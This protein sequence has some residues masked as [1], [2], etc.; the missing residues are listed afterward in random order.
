M[1]TP[2]DL[3]RDPRLFTTS[4]MALLI[5]RFGVE[6]MEWDPITVGLEIESE[7]GIEPTTE[8]QDR[9]QAGCSLYTSNLFFVS[10]ETFSTICN[11]LNFGSTTSQILLPADLDDVMWGCSEA[12]LILGDIYDEKQFSHNVRLFT[13]ALL[14]EAGFVKPPSILGFAEF[15]EDMVL[16]SDEA[17]AGDEHMRLSFWADQ[18]H[19]KEMLETWNQGKIIALMQQLKGLPLKNGSPEFIQQTLD[20]LKT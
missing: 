18:E 19:E 10:L 9:I 11:T 1:S 15:T 14:K 16:R 6:F 3:L 17:F 5:D 4:A 8:L 20:R 13:G 2:E 7:Y 12:M